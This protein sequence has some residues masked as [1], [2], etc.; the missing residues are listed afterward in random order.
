MID[1]FTQYVGSA[2]DA[3]PAVLCGIAHMQTSEGVWY[4][5]GGTRAVPE[6]LT[7]LATELGVEFTCDTEITSIE[8]SGVS[9]T[10]CA[11]IAVSSCHSMR[12]SPIVIPAHASRNCCVE[13]PWLETWR[14]MVAN[15]LALVWCSTWDCPRSTT[16]CCTTILV[17]SKDPHEDFEWINRRGQPAPDPTCYWC[18]PAVTEPGVAPPGG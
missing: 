10:A 1:H 18:A 3:S 8:T 12:L 4:L 11:P 13:L 6:A 2:P 5:D 17:F 15:R 7:K 9:V 14:R 16:I